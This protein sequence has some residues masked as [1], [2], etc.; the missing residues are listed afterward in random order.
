MSQVSA[1]QTKEIQMGLSLTDGE[2]IT[3]TGSGAALATRL[4]EAAQS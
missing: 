4:Y 1:T 3:F 2:L